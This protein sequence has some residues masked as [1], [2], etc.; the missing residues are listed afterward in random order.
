MVYYTRGETEQENAFI[1]E[2]GS[3]CEYQSKNC[4]SACRRGYSLLI[5]VCNTY[6]NTWIKLANKNGLKTMYIRGKNNVKDRLWKL[7]IVT[8]EPE[9]ITPVDEDMYEKMSAERHKANQ[10]SNNKVRVGE[11]KI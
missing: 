11:I 5:F 6:M 10:E 8:E 9:D 3:V 4:S 7:T 2:R 1:R